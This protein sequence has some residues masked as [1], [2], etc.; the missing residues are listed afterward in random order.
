M[1]AIRR[2]PRTQ[3]AALDAIGPSPPTVVVLN[4][5][6]SYSFNDSLVMDER[7]FLSPRCLVFLESAV[8]N[9]YQHLRSPP[10]SAYAALVFV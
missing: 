4:Q 9:D 5:F 3:P 6:D 8:F 7:G 1:T 10:P 2:L